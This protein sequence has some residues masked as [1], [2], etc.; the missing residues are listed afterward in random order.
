MDMINDRYKIDWNNPIGYGPRVKV[1][2][3]ITSI[4]QR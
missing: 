4:V 3:V 2:K 1:H